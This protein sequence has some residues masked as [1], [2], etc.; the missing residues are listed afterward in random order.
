MWNGQMCGGREPP[1][2]PGE[3]LWQVTAIVLARAEYTS[4]AA[5]TNRSSHVHGT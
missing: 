5:E 2:H 4:P 3:E 1:A